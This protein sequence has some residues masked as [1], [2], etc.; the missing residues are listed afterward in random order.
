MT[1]TLLWIHRTLGLTLAPYVLV[2]GLSGVALLWEGDAARSF[3]I[4]PVPRVAGTPLPVD[5][6]VATLGRR[7]PAFHI[8]SLWWPRG[9][10]APWFAEVKQG[11][12]GRLGETAMAVYL[13][14]VS[15]AV[16]HVHDYG[17]SPW[18]WLQVLHINLLVG[19]AGRT[20]NAALALVTVF[21]LLTGVLLWMTRYRASTRPYKIDRSVPLWRRTWQLHQ[22]VGVYALAFLLAQ[23]LTGAYFGWSAPAAKAIAAMFPMQVLNR[24]MPPVTHPPGTAMRPVSVF[25]PT[26]HQ[27]VP[28]HGVTRVLFPERPTQPIRFVV[29]EGGPREAHKASALF[30]NPWTGRLLRADLLRDQGIGD[31]IVFL[32]GAIHDGTLGGPLVHWVWSGGGVCFPVL[33]ITGGIIAV[34]RRSV[35]HRPNSSQ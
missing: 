6:V 27:L 17:T 15:G 30:F 34:R 35:R 1:R 29:Y 10:N 7:F 2:M 21:L 24:P 22:V 18:R 19:R 9:I 12:T 8:H 26:V 5:E 33:A 4:P 16:L 31:R 14:P 13:H 23:C 3:R 32:I 28:K 25:L 11:E 20:W